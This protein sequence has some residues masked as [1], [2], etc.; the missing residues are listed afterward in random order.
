MK[1]V[2]VIYFITLVLLF[3]G[4]LPVLKMNSA[5]NYNEKFEYKNFSLIKSGKVNL[6]RKKISRVLNFPVNFES[7]G[8]REIIIDLSNHK[9]MNDLAMCISFSKARVKLY[10]DNENIYEIDSAKEQMSGFEGGLQLSIIDLPKDI[11]NPKMKLFFT[12]DK[13]YLS[14]ASLN[15]IRI[16]DRLSIVMDFIHSEILGL[17]ISLV[18]MFLSIGSFFISIFQRK[19]KF[20]ANKLSAFSMILFVT[21]IYFLSRYQ[22]I[23]YIFTQNRNFISFMEYTS[24]MFFTYPML[25][26][27][28]DS[29]E[30]K[31]DEYIHMNMTLCLINF[32][33]QTVLVFIFGKTFQKLLPFTNIVL[34]ITGLSTLLMLLKTDGNKYKH[35]KSLL[36]TFA[37]LYIA[38]ISMNIVYLNKRETYTSIIPVVNIGLFTLTQIYILIKVY[39]QVQRENLN[40]DNYKK[41]INKDSLTKANSRYA[42]NEFI[43]NLRKDPRK[44]TF[45]SVDVNNLKIINDNYGHTVGDKAIIK[46]GNYLM[47]KIGKDSV[48]RIGGDE[49]VVATEYELNDDDIEFLKGENLYINTRLGKIEVFY[50]IGYCVYDPDGDLSIDEAIEEADKQMYVKKQALK[51][52][53]YQTFYNI[54][55]IE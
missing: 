18:L 36:I 10:V 17:L 26:I 14:R 31:F 9:D 6:G 39:I 21:V 47:E 8:T 55:N 49:Y 35:K 3:M 20:F 15:F 53:V 11:K 54:E 19:N 22:T 16:G 50:A 30:P 27:L 33:V 52:K 7:E 29:I 4:I 45:M 1:K 37:P 38:L 13:D 40:M 41:L 48:Y 32:F 43:I 5:T 2:K 46:V 34:F 25:K 44:I 28:K 42:F 23:N 24:L 12:P 51:P